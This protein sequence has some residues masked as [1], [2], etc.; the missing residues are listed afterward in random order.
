MQENYLRNS[1]INY[2]RLLNNL[3]VVVYHFVLPHKV[4]FANK[5]FYTFFKVN[6]DQISKEEFHPPI[7]PNDSEIFDKMLL[8]LTSGNNIE[9]MKLRIN[10]IDVETKWTEWNISPLTDS[11]NE[12]TEY[13]VLIQD[14]T[15]RRKSEYALKQ[16]EQQ[17]KLIFDQAADMI[18][19]IDRMGNFLDLNTKFEEESGW[20][21]KEIIGKNIFTSRII[22]NESA[23]KISSN[24]SRIISGINI[25]E[26][27]IQGITK[28]GD[29]IDFELHAVPLV[30]DGTVIAFQAILRNIK[31]RKI[32]FKAL[33][34]SQRQLSNL[35]SNL[36]GM[37]YR[38][39]YDDHWT[40][41]FVSDGSFDLTGYPPDA[42][43]GNNLIS[44]GHIIV[45]E[46]KS[47]VTDEVNKAIRQ[48]KPFR[49]NYRIKTSEGKT[50]WVWEQGSAVKNSLGKIEA[51]EGFIADITEQKQIQEALR[52]NE[53]LYKKLI[54]ALPDMI[55][56][57]DLN[58]N[59]LFMND[60]G[61][62]I[63]GY[64]SFEDLKKENIL[65]FI[66]ARDKE[67][68]SENFKERISG[69]IG[70]REY[71]FFDS[72][73][74]EIEFEVNG[75]VLKDK[76][77]KP[78]GL[79]FACRD[80]RLRKQAEN[81]LAQSEEQYRTLVD[82]IQDGVFLIQNGLLKFVNKSFADIIGY[83]VDELIGLDF[84]EVVA[85]EDID[86]V[87]GNYKKRQEGLEVPSSYE[88][89][90][91]HKNGSR[92][93]VNMNVR[94]I[95]YLGNIASIGTV[96]NIS[97]RK[98]M[99]EILLRQKNILTGAAESS[100]ILLTEPDFNAAIEKTL[101]ILGE[102]TSVDRVYIFENSTDVEAG[103]NYMSQKYEWVKEKI[104]PQIQNPEL[105]LLPYEPDFSEW[106]KLFSNGEYVWSL[107][108]DLQGEQKRIMEAEDILS[109][110]EVPIKIKDKLWG[111]IGFDDCHEE[112][113]WTES[114]ISILKAAAG[115]IGGAI[116]RENTKKELIAAK[117][118]AEEMNRLKSNFLANMSHELRTPLIAILGY[119]EL[120][121]LETDN[122]NWK[123]MLETIHSGG[124]RLL[125]TLNDLLDLSKIEADK[126]TLNTEPI[127]VVDM[128]NEVVSLFRSISEKKGIEI[129][130]I[131]NSQSIECESDKRI[132]RSILNNLVSNAV[133][134]TE[135][136]NVQVETL[137][138]NSSAGIAIVFTVSDS[139]I[140]IS[141]KGKEIIFDEFRQ[142]S[143][144]LSRHFE[145][146]G[147]GLTITKKF[148]E[149]LNGTIEFTSELG[150]GSTFT[151]SI[152]VNKLAVNE[153]SSPAIV[154]E[155]LKKKSGSRNKII[156]VDD[157]PASRSVISLF[158]RKEY[159][160]DSAA[161]GEEAVVMM[162]TQFYDMILLDISLGKGINGLDLVKLIRKKKE[163]YS[164]PVMAVTAHA[165][166]GDREKFLN[167]GFNDYIAKPFTKQEL[168]KKV[169]GLF[170]NK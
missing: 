98:K 169:S 113:E 54:S 69:N 127:N 123:T 33:R 110:L 118:K 37:A 145:G 2:I 10:L 73:G 130:T 58:G 108:K 32:V 5:S 52:E 42:L 49:L 132:L 155:L 88:W 128:V 18:V 102:K 50:R 6:P 107:V 24:L 139:G 39:K 100:N 28:K 92:I 31:D 51:I 14:L 93:Y 114:E 95:S 68:A 101:N 57:T 97:Q 121:K 53:E 19:I 74:N 43:I 146:T 138:S 79:I 67:K 129:K 30:K 63:S 66:A 80:I 153:Y 111:F 71:T 78:Y 126:I 135:R 91:M 117:E 137:F 147:L 150:K 122:E 163:Y 4:I 134:F 9:N 170:N 159:D 86:L 1:D 15:D 143:E 85:P 76:D 35:M 87:T 120:L 44:Y 16:G 157:D 131:F 60:L 36:P 62:K 38:C 124:G 75:E 29:V 154:D 166:V 61:L 96:K 94:L 151:V 165:M 149:L 46:D 115:S 168:M 162:K 70:A 133:K 99:E 89:R 40:M 8:S 81:A 34:E 136:G 106:Y 103:L 119:A 156:I 105:Q 158:L 109:I 116:E 21:K 48:D 59:I 23:H 7:H 140:G 125:D 152:P 82:S 25:P 160:V 77:D 112:R 11:T 164:I 26:F 41:E 142:A 56:I 144:G 12:L 13:Q 84:R 65:N 17:Y 83:S 72:N 47:K 55:V 167:E 141:E 104:N 90:M 148:V 45:K 161:T 20:K 64:S 27:E 3:P 22:T